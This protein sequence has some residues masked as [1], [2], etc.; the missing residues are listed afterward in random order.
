MCMQGVAGWPPEKR[1]GMQVMGG[2]GCLFYHYE[3]VVFVFLCMFQQGH[4]QCHP[5]L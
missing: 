2:G 5:A 4:I 1:V 3:N